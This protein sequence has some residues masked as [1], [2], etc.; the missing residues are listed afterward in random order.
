MEFHKLRKYYAMHFFVLKIGVFFRI[1]QFFFQELLYLSLRFNISCLNIRV[2]KVSNFN[3][4]SIHFQLFYVQNVLLS[5]EHLLSQE[6]NCSIHNNYACMAQIGALFRHLSG[7]MHFFLI[8]TA[9]SI[10][11]YIEST[12]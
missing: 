8:H 5:L 12:N 1:L 2:D 10:E 6:K 4:I 3:G 9:L 11:L 7:N